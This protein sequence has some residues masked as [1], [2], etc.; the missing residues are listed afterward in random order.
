MRRVR[1]RVEHEGERGAKV[2][3]HKMAA[4]NCAHCNTLV[5]YDAAEVCSWCTG[6]LCKRACPSRPGGCKRPADSDEVFEEIVESSDMPPLVV[7]TGP[8]VDDLRRNVL[9]AAVADRDRWKKVAEAYEEVLDESL[10]DETVLREAIGVMVPIIIRCFIQVCEAKET[11]VG[12]DVDL[13][14]AKKTLARVE[15]AMTPPSPVAEALVRLVKA[16]REKFRPF[17]CSSE[18][19][20]MTYCPVHGAKP[21]ADDVLRVALTDYTSAL[22]G[23]R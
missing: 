17:C 18:H 8:W 3:E 7:P 2:S 16:V 23:G 22:R 5:D 1:G 21:I 20:N 6:P 11:S 19:G 15:A 12:R 9:A 4:L 10:A 14:G 13:D